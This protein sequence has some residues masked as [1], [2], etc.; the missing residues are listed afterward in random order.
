MPAHLSTQQVE[1]YLKRTMTPA[2]LLAAGDHLASCPDCRSQLAAANTVGARV[3]ELR[4][5]FK[6]QARKSLE[7]LDYEQLAA[8][9][10]D[11]LDEVDREI[12]DS[13]VAV[14]APCK[15]ELRDLFAFRETLVESAASPTVSGSATETFWSKAKARW[16][17]PASASRWAMAAGM[18]A[19]V[20]IAAVAWLALRT[21]RDSRMAKVEPTPTPTITQTPSPQVSPSDNQNDQTPTPEVSPTAQPSPPTINDRT[22]EPVLALNDNGEK[23]TVDAKGE[24]AGLENLPTPERQAARNALLNGRLET[25]AVLG[26]LKVNDVTLMGGSDAD[27][28]FSVISPAGTVVSSAR[29]AFRWRPLEGATSYTIK[30]YDTNFNMI[31]SS[32]TLNTA[33]WSPAKP[34]APGRIY[35]WQVVAVKDGQEVISPAPSSPEARFKVLGAAQAAE[36]KQSLAA[37]GNSHLARGIIYTRAGVLDEAEREFELLVR[38]NPQSSAARKLLNNAR[39]MRH[40]KK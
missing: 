9:V 19:L 3:E 39:A 23:V 28:S 32:G 7:H 36:L 27:K 22:S 2:E 34:L 5:D 10:D 4:A 35:T 11:Q 31:A 25:P 17:R 38:E 26:E 15:E 30:V 1:Q 37:S 20:L 29:P 33:Q 40:R 21:Q 14:C 13:H 18:A 8:Y 6:E 16:G 24:L 12:V